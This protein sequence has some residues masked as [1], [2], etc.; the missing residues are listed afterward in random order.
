MMD[1]EHTEEETGFFSYVAAPC[2]QDADDPFNPEARMDTN[3]ATGGQVL[4]QGAEVSVYGTRE[5]RTLLVVATD[6]L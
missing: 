5:E 6:P 3:T 4:S 2:L 1:F